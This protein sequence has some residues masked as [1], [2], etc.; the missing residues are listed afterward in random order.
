MPTLNQVLDINLLVPGRA[1][2]DVDGPIVATKVYEELFRGNAEI[3][4]TDTIPY[5]LDDAMH[6]LR[7][8]QGVHVV[9]WATYAHLGV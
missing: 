2:G 1:M 7:E 3:L 4:D 9:R 5:A 8:R 6:N